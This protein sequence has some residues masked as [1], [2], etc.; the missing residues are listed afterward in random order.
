MNGKALHPRR[1]H[2]DRPRLGASWSVHTAV[3]Q[4][5]ASHRQSRPFLDMIMLSRT[6]GNCAKHLLGTAGNNHVAVQKLAKRKA[7][8][9]GAVRRRSGGPTPYRCSF[10]FS[11]DDRPADVSSFV[12][13]L[14]QWRSDPRAHPEPLRFHRHAHRLRNGGPLVSR[15]SFW[16]I[17]TSPA[18]PIC[19]APRGPPVSLTPPRSPPPPPARLPALPRPWSAAPRDR[20]RALR[21]PRAARCGRR[22]PARGP[23]LGQLEEA[24]VIV[25][26]LPPA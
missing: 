10:G 22:R 8:A 26:A 12:H 9:E 2:V 19:P 20:W 4:V 5:R 13:E 1:Q 23:E 6:T 21:H 16:R 14:A 3:D 15:S 24:D 18:G 11:I 17:F 25:G 7:S